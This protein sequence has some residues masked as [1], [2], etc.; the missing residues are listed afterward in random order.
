MFF[1]NERHIFL[2]SEKKNQNR[3]KE[4]KIREIIPGLHSQFSS[5]LPRSPSYMLAIA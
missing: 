1:R 2:F 3:D 5:Y 4:Q